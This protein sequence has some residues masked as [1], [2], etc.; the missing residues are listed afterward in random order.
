MSP[1]AESLDAILRLGPAPAAKA[2]GFSK[3]GRTFRRRIGDCIQ[4]TNLQAS[5][6]NSGT[7]GSFTLNLGL[8]FPKAAALH[9]PAPVSDRP[10]ESLCQLR[11]RI[12]GLMPGSEDHWWQVTPAT[13]LEPLAADVARHWVQAGLPWLERFVTPE[14]AAAELV[15]RGVRFDAA[16][17][18][19]SHGD[20]AAAERLVQ[21]VLLSQENTL[22]RQYVAAWAREQGLESG[23]AN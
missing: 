3:S 22:H 12:G 16:V 15:R 5:L 7:T 20:R 23:L 17:L 2:A 19:L 11:Q 4:V 8:Y 18:Y 6:T 14:A 13:A 21:E 10:S 9:S 1:I